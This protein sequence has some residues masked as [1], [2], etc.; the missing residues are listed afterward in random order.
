MPDHTVMHVQYS[1]GVIILTVCVKATDEYF[2][3][4]L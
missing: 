3:L 4:S 1:N 2:E